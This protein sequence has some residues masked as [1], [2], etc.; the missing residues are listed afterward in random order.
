MQLDLKAHDLSLIPGKAVSGL[1][2]VLLLIK[3]LYYVLI[4]HLRLITRRK[5]HETPALTK[6]TNMGISVVG[7][8][9]QLITRSS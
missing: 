3:P 5:H 8:T 4:R 2:H 9:N 6:S 1:P 7:T